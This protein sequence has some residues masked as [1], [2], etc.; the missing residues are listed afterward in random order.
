MHSRITPRARPQHTHTHTRPT[1]TPLTNP[2]I[3]SAFNERNATPLEPPAEARPHVTG[4]G[5]GNDSGGGNGIGYVGGSSNGGAGNNGGGSGG[6][7][8]ENGPGG[9]GVG[10]GGGG[11]SGSGGGGGGNSVGSRVCIVVDGPED[12]SDAQHAN[13]GARP[14]LSPGG[15]LRPRSREA[16]PP[17]RR[18]CCVLPN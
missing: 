18:S 8:G 6:G 4:S 16:R 15:R 12:P 17:H 10:S 7:G 9:N 11:S 13:R 3:Q 2:T 5:G 14:D 1:D